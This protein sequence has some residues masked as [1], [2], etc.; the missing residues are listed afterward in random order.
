MATESLNPPLKPDDVVG[1]YA[2]VEQIGSG[3]TSVVYKGN[4]TLINKDVAI[5]Q[6]TLADSEGTL[7][8]RVEQE[9]AIQKKVAADAP[10]QVVQP[11]ETIDD[12]RGLML[13]SEYVD[14]PS[15]EWILSQ[16]TD[17]MPEKQALGILAGTAASL[18]AIHDHGIIHRDLK[19]SNILL[20][21]KGG[22]KV[23][24]F[25]LAAALA[26]QDT[27]SLGSVRYM[28]PELFGDGP[29]DARADLYSLGMIGY[30]MLAGR[31]KFDEA[32]RVVT[33]DQR[34]Q[35]MRWM[36]WHTNLRSKAPP[37]TQL[38]PEIDPALSDLIARLMEKDPSA[39]VT[40]ARQLIDAIRRHFAKA[41]AKPKTE[42]KPKPEE[43]LPAT[44]IPPG[45]PA[46]DRPGPAPV[47]EPSSTA[48]LPNARAIWPWLVGTAVAA[49]IVLGLGGGIWYVLD[50]QAR[51]EQRQQAI[52]EMYD[53]AIDAYD[54]RRYAEAE[55]GF[56]E[57]TGAEMVDP[58]LRIRGLAGLH[59]S[60]G[61]LALG[62]ERYQAAI[63]EF[64]TAEEYD[65]K[66]IDATEDLIRSARQT[67]AFESIVAAIQ[68]DIEQGH[69]SQGLEK[70]REWRELVQSDEES[71]TL[72][73]LAAQ[74]G[75][76]QVSDRVSK[77]LER[78]DRLTRTGQRSQAI[79]EL[80]EMLERSPAGGGKL[81][82][83]LNQLENSTAFDAA[84]ARGTAAETTGKLED[85]LQAYREAAGIRKNNA[86]AKRKLANVES[87]LLLRE[88]LRLLD[89]GKPLEA[90]RA[91]TRSLGLK[92]SPQARAALGRIESAS[93][94]DS[95]IRA[96]DQAYE[97]GNYEIAV[98]QYSNALEI[99]A[100][101]AVE[102]KLKRAQ[103]LDR[104]RLALDAMEA[105]DVREAESHI[106][107]ATRIMPD[108][109]QVEAVREQFEIRSEYLR[110]RDAGNEAREKSKFGD[111]KYNFERARRVADTAEIQR[112]LN[113]TEYDHLVAQ[114]RSYLAVGQ[115]V[116]ARALL[117][118]AAEI[119]V[120]QEI[121]DMLEEIERFLPSEEPEEQ[122]P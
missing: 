46:I 96:G 16:V 62:E 3:G 52:S 87:T 44:V 34:N 51:A 110:F 59:L 53:R 57:V 48:P 81:R 40:D 97:V 14:G 55:A 90:E 21:R 23:A 58:E 116:P 84:M 98:K 39:R 75:E 86:N 114:A 111:A 10:D 25:G 27:L 122:T 37:L 63:D 47:A 13:V 26:E 105:G 9:A 108:D 94:Q 101:P 19:P 73:E 82:Q 18:K 7:R 112:L 71:Q 30:E 78:V 88:G 31:T 29:V 93:Q 107:A 69:Y 54:Q 12:P 89:Q 106:V 1:P 83:R 120:T 95:F 49:V 67:A 68:T 56:A 8:D 35:S 109:P 99:S 70:I 22:L 66:R 77:T 28:A 102:E 36:K 64:E 17:P 100:L 92:D 121:D 103:V 4:D 60:R 79:A 115:Y 80:R 118:T 2:I 104:L 20:P 119:R 32:F 43:A 113:E 72:R 42:N 11:I 33:R 45:T 41:A 61:R 24:D 6:I 15:L 50:A 38:V 74:L 76:M 91:L 5:K 85:A 65:A 117:R